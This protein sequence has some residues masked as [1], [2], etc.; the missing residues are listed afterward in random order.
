MTLLIMLSQFASVFAL[1]MNSKLLR[2][3]R[4]IL[5]ML[6]SWMISATQFT[7]VWVVS[8]AP[9]DDR[10]I[11]FLAAAFGGSLGCGVSH[12]VYTHKIMR[13]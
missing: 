13:K 6:N 9:S 1:V 5:A 12:L 10:L 11:T 3:D 8:Q 7:F 2:D 4:W